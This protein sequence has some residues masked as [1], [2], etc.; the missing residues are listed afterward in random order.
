[1]T[2]SYSSDVFTIAPG[3]TLYAS[4]IFKS[5]DFNQGGDFQGPMVL[6]ALAEPP[7]QTVT[8]STVGVERKGGENDLQSYC[9][10][11]WSLR[12]DGSETVFVSPIFFYD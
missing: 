7:N 10:Y 9:V 5:S 8:P 11:H 4:T 1:M 6:C 2:T 12:N 3:A